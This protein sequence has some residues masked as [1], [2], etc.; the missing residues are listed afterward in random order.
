MNIAFPAERPAY[1]A[2]R[3]E[4][5]FD[6][7]VDGA[8]VGCAITAEALKDHF[9]AASLREPDLVS[10]FDAHRAAIEAAA[11]R[12]LEETRGQPVV[13]HSGFFRLYGEH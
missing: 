7:V 9:G 13:L 10:A 8:R 4:L 3:P 11:A 5:T 2:D 12:M 6:A 1:H